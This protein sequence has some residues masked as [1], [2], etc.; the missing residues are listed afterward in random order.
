M[1]ARGNATVSLWS[2]LG[3]PLVEVEVEVD[4]LRPLPEKHGHIG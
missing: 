1:F 3:T 4:V 2:A